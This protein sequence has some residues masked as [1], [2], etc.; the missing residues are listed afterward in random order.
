MTT[1]GR[2][3]AGRVLAIFAISFAALFASTAVARADAPANDD[4]A[5]AT[6]LPSLPT[7]QSGSN[8]DATK[9]PGEPDHAG[10]AG[11]HSVWFSWTATSTGP[12][13]IQNGSCFSAVEPLIA[14]YTG[15]SVDSLTPVASN[16]SPYSLSCFSEGPFAEFEATAGTTYLIAV[17]GKNG[18]E[19]SFNLRFATAPENDDF[20]DATAISGELPV[21]W[22]GTIRLARKEPGEPNHAGNSGG[23]SVWFAW[24]P[25]VSEPVRISTCTSFARFDAVLAVYTGSSV[26]ALTEVASNDETPRPIGF[27]GCSGAD[28]E[29]AID[30]VAGTTYRIAVDGAG[31]TAG[32]FM[33]QIRGRPTNDDFDSPQV[34]PPNLPSFAFDVNNELATEEIGE[35][36][37]AGASGGRSLWFS[38]TPASSG[39]VRVAA[40]GSGPDAM[41]TALAVYTGSDLSGLS[42]IAAADGGPNSHCGGGSEVLITVTAGTTYRI[43]VDGEGGSEGSFGLSLEG[44]GNHDNFA[45]AKILPETLGVSASGSTT[46]ATKEVGEPNHAGDSGG[47]SIWFSWTAP[48]SGPVAISVC[49]YFEEAP[50]TLLGVYTGNAVGSLTSVAANDDSPAA[51]KEVGSEVEI[52]AVAGTTYRIAVDGKDGSAGI[53]S[54][55]I[56]GRP[57]ND[58]FESAQ[59]L[60]P[61]SVLS[62]GSNRFAGKEA[63]E[64]NHAGLPGGHSLWFTWTPAKSGPV[65]IVACGL[66]PGIDTLLGV[67]TGSDLN[68]LTPVASGDDGASIPDTEIC[69]SGDTETASEAGFEAVAGTTYRIAVDTKD[70]EGPVRLY[71]DVAPENDSFSSPRTL[72]PSLPGFYADSTE[73]ASLE[74]G[75][76][77]HGGSPGGNSVWF[78]WTAPG[79]GP[80]AI[81]TCTR[82]GDLDALLGVYAGSELDSLTP[83]AAGD[84]G[85]DDWGCRSTDGKA[86]FTASAGTRYLI[87]VD[88]KGGT[89]GGFQLIFEGVAPGDDFAKA[90]PLGGTL[91]ASWQFSSNRF[92]G[93]QAG[94]PNHAGDPGGS[95][96]WVKWTAPR[97]GTVSVDTCDS[98]FDTLLA[99]Y[100]GATLGALTPVASN[101]DGSGSCAPQSKL[102]FEAVANTTYRIAVDGKAG[103]QGRLSL[104]I[105]GRPGNDDFADADVIPG[106]LGLYWLGSTMLATEQAGEPDHEGDPGGSSIWLSWTPRQSWLVELD[107]CTSGFEPLLAVYT[108]AAH[109]SLT[110][111]PATDAGKG[112][113]DEGRSIAFAAVAGTTYRIAVDGPGGDEGRVQLR[114]RDAGTPEH[115]LTVS[116]AGAGAG[117]VT[118]KP[119]G[120]DCGATCS[121]DFT[122]GTPLTLIAIPAAGSTFTGWSG[123]GCSGTGTCQLTLNADAAVT[124][125]FAPVLGGGG[126]G[127]PPVVTPPAPP[128]PPPAPKTKP[129]PKKCKRGFKKKMVK[130]KPRCVKKKKKQKQRRS[131]AR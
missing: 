112:R 14:V 4:F 107:A 60:Y 129:K 89:S 105:E 55:D 96:V 12:V 38:W 21:K 13:S 99:V 43:A 68:A 93:K 67:Y 52:D 66:R 32:S 63:G 5:D 74:A 17:D 7:E 2:V 54:L 57:S 9:E 44:P 87:A 98:G 109:D 6:V 16:A 85:N 81:S 110:P 77:D 35:P 31:G 59:A 53:F 103:A 72:D 119:S 127:T 78:A 34:L 115:T 39:R 29:V 46:L 24:T 106:R 124:A 79:S 92:A 97:S 69:E 51:C 122:E 22:F 71:L 73:R 41:E 121:H 19:G 70:G 48:A 18:A 61:G 94:E 82:E 28:G 80:V 126:S 131:R 1:A 76:P 83:V 90:R 100:T 125:T 101:D 11:G 23:R 65:D 108:G 128:S 8:V 91:P 36:D 84:D 130:G 47:N 15:S 95:S 37:H 111:V 33:L 30:A 75:E 118:S 40:C 64:P 50:D 58:D 116:R 117:T 20:A 120:I 45:D 102:S 10:N 27:P 49:P 88:G 56:N 86:Q 104:H 26:G 42:P 25:S 3:Q 113:C 114:L 123:G 62:G